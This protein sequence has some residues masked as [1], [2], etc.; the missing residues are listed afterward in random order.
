ML[1]II[2]DCDVKAI[3]FFE[4]WSVS[5]YPDVVK[6]FIG[7]GYELAW[8]GFQHEMWSKLSTKEEE[9]FKKKFRRSR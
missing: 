3:F 6:D 2:D 8:H 4:S 7:R 9:I 1:Q 5:V